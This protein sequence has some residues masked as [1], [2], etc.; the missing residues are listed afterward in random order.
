[1]TENQAADLEFSFSN[2]SS[3]SCSNNFQSKVKLVAPA[4][5]DQ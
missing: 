2:N 1:V 3:Q 5:I 4:T